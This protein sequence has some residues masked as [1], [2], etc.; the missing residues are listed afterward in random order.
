M[1]VPPGD[2]GSVADARLSEAVGAGGAQVTDGAHDGAPR[3][4]TSRIARNTG[5]QVAGEVASKVASLA[6][7][8]VMARKLGQQSFGDFTFAVSV[9]L[10]IEI[11]GLGTDILVTKEIAQDRGRAHGL[12]WNVNSIKLALGSLGV[13]VAVAIVYA[14]RYPLEVRLVV[15]LL[16]L[17]KLAEIVAKTFY[18]ALRG[19]EDMAPTAIGLMLQRFFTAVVGSAIM[20][21]GA[22]L[23][24]VTVVYLIGALL[25]LA[26]IWRR[27]GRR[28]LRPEMNL[29]FSAARSLAIASLPIGLSWVFATIL[30]RLDAVLLSL[31]KSNAAVGLYGA[32]Y[33]A[34][35]ATL[36]VSWTFGVS[37]LPALS[38]LTRASRP[39]LAQ[40]Y[41]AAC[42][43]LTAI[44]FPVGAAFALFGTT[45]TT[46]VYGQSFADAATPLRL[47]AGATALYGL[48]I[49]SVQ[50][51]AAQDRRTVLAP[52]SAFVAI[53]NAALN[54]IL[55]PRYSFN[56]AAAAMTLSQATLT[57]LTAIAAIRLTG[58]ISAT[59][60][61]LGPLVGCA[62]M[63]GI[64]LALGDTVGGL[65][66][67]AAAYP[68][69][70]YALERRLFP[71]DLRLIV[72]SLRR[73]PTTQP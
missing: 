5:V 34:F 23:V 55:I 25:A 60:T 67:A 54:V 46:A 11:A 24:P 10:L 44:L 7:F 4:A 53:E 68:V 33:R 56:G 63:C 41:A 8:A 3:V 69:V 42:K 15:A 29:S 32:A 21:A 51:L 35:E 13:A 47:L 9:V 14:G 39:T 59:R 62:A 72:G 43:V 45:I 18:A 50:V 71:A 26:Y 22:G 70:T 28:G 30:A 36:F 38:R 66:C 64:A 17:A 65:V 61:L 49:I 20:F 73:R 27:V 12:I 16:A 48:F 19:I 52:I 58:R 37:T 31:F 40:A 57:A 2:T 1:T 6:F